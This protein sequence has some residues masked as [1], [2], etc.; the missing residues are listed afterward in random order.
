MLQQKNNELTEQNKRLLHIL[1]MGEVFC[2]ERNLEK[3]L[4]LMMKEISFL[5]DADRSSLF[6]IDWE[7]QQL[8]TKYA[9]GM[10]NNRIEVGLKMGLA[11]QCVLTRKI[12]NVASAYDSYFFNAGIDKQTGFRTQS[13]LCAP[14][15]NQK[16]EVTGALEFL[17]KKSGVFTGQDE[18]KI[19]RFAETIIAC[20]Y[21]SQ[22]DIQEVKNAVTKLRDELNC[23]RSALFLVNHDN[24]E[25]RSVF[26]DDVEGWNILLNLNLGIAG[27]VALTSEAI[28]I[29]DVYQDPR[30]D[31]RIDEM[32][33][34]RTKCLL[35]AP[36][37]TATGDILGAIEVMNKNDGVFTC[38]D[39]DLLK[40]LASYLSIF[41]ENAI[42]FNE[43]TKQFQ[44]VLEVLAASIDA[45][46]NLTSG[47]S[48]RVAQYATGI[49]SE[50]GFNQDD[51]DT[52]NV[53]ALLHDYGKLGTDDRI[54]KK[55]G[56]LTP[57]EYEHIKQ[58]VVNT[59][60]ILGKMAFSRKYKSVPVLASQ[61]HERLDGSGYMDGMS[62]AEI[63]FMGRIIA[64]ADVFEALTAKR[65]YRDAM[66]IN[67][68]FRIL[69]ED[70]GIKY[71]HHVIAA[72]KSY[73]EKKLM[74]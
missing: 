62:G 18:E 58:H 50:L 42:L 49:A 26:A 53:A 20:D 2:R 5:L 38:N 3:L 63:P 32:T 6:L 11:G 31:K 45:K 1:S 43:Q 19:A 13:V 8:W 44:S 64:V 54:L 69:E 65:H 56:R 21:A 30:F 57:D 17:N 41:L 59:R 39:M 14:I 52:L 72:L 25:L 74:H 70:A 66:P 29:G 12:I 47:H 36:L 67:E 4:P 16:Q 10:E 61:H 9:E 51:I 73:Y 60:N 33:G 34:Y 35:C 24:G 40:F 68:A 48:L 23:E 46:D 27:L 15:F 55:P 22:L 37:Q 71:D 7:S 28:N